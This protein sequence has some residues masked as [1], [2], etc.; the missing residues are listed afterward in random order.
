M[1]SV[2]T[3]KKR[4]S[5]TK[6]IAKNMN[7]ISIVKR[8]NGWLARR[9]GRRIRT[10]HQTYDNMAYGGHKYFPLKIEAFPLNQGWF[11]KNYKEF[12]SNKQTQI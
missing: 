6:I 10:F 12:W 11:N 5:N 7:L 2:V 8:S 9:R 3:T 1:G 4:D